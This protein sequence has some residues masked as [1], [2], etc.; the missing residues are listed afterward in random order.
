MRS[1]RPDRAPPNRGRPPARCPARHLPAPGPHPQ[2]R[3]GR[4]P[5]ARGDV[6]QRPSLTF[7]PPRVT[8]ARSEGR[9]YPPES[10]PSAG[11][12]LS[13]GGLLPEV[14]GRRRAAAPSLITAVVLFG[15]IGLISPAPA[16][17]ADPPNIDGFLA[18]LGAVE[19]N[20]RYDAVNATSG[21]IGKYQ[22]LPLNW[23][24]WARR[25]LGDENAA[26]SPG[27][28]EIVA[29]RKVIALYGWLGA[30]APVAHWWLTGDGDLNPDNWSDFSRN[31][32]NRIL[33]RIG[34]PLLP[35]R[36]EGWGIESF[37]GRAYD[38]SSGKIT[39]S[40][41][42]G[43]AGYSRYNGGIVRYATE[44]G[45]SAIFTFTGTA[46]SVVGPIGPTRG[47]ARVYVDGAFIGTMSATA[48]HFRARVR[49]FTMTFDVVATHTIR[50]EVVGSGSHPMVAL[51]EFVVE[52]EPLAIE[53]PR[54]AAMAMEVPDALE[55]GP[56][57]AQR[58]ATTSISIR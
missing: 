17:A 15:L 18:A 28:Q 43:E 21:A 27:N 16:R 7:G 37:K 31:Y 57:L 20:G 1:L 25:Y 52:G 51:D 14:T 5:R 12:A 13:G 36:P 26:P 8:V 34:E 42:W 3:P 47:D 50:L 58:A 46:I 33:A 40:E 22:I 29:R 2:T 39:L 32:V 54:V 19:S 23:R 35:G 41:G 49:I 48:R 4:C 56:V 45:A 24:A 55:P 9:R 38:D 10:A 53:V 11:A 6:P 44:P 30:W